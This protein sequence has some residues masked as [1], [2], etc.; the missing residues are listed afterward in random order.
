M[1]DSHEMPLFQNNNKKKMRI[2]SATILL[3]VLKIKAD[4][5]SK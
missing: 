3:S 2:L 1:E 4:I 5:I